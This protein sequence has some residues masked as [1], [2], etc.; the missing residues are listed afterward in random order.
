M[1]RAL[2]EA[3]C[4]LHAGFTSK[5]EYTP[6]ERAKMGRNEGMAPKVA[7]PRLLTL[8][9]SFRLQDTVRLTS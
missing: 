5:D 1:K 8:L 4:S 2:G 6:E 3:N 7:L 9:C